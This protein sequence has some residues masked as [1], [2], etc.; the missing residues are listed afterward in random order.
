MWFD[1]RAMLAELRANPPATTATTATVPARVADVASVATP[2][3]LELILDL[4]EERAAIR[5]YDGGQTCA[6]A[7]AGALGDV[8]R[9]TRTDTEALHRLWKGGIHDRR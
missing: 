1:A 8:A 9:S 7:E 3:D 6:D 5:K 2:P 4:L